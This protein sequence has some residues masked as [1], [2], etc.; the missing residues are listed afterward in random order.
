MRTRIPSL[1]VVL[2][3]NASLSVLVLGLS[4]LGH[5]YVISPPPFPKMYVA[6]AAGRNRERKVLAD[7]DLAFLNEQADSKKL[8]K[9]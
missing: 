9:R 8:M 6:P 2:K 3:P 7:L 5:V 4:L 1:M